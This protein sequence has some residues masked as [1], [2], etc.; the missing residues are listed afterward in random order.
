MIVASRTQNLNIKIATTPKEL[1]TSHRSSNDQ[2]VSTIERLLNHSLISLSTPRTH[3]SANRT[4]KDKNTQDSIV[5]W[6]IKINLSAKLLS[7]MELSTPN[8][9][10]MELVKTSQSNLSKQ[11]LFLI[12][13]PWRL[14]IQLMSATTRLWVEVLQFKNRLSTSI[15]RRRK[16]TTSNI[17]RMCV[18]QFGAPPIKWASQWPTP[19]SQITSA[20]WESTSR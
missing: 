9:W 19:Q 10:L 2:V 8:R 3:T 7:S 11:N 6:C 12:M 16:R 20:M 4:W 14:V 13:D 17:K 1:T 5:K 18:T 15:K